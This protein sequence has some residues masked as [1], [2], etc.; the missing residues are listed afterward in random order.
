M[1]ASK[2]TIFNTRLS[3]IKAGGFSGQN[4]PPATLGTPG[5]RGPKPAGGGKGTFGQKLS[6]LT[7]RKAAGTIA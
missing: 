2:P 4:Q 6:S 1:S 7:R 5:D 3:E